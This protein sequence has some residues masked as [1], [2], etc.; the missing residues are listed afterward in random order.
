MAIQI[1]IN[2]TQ[3]A[4]LRTILELGPE[5]LGDVVDRIEGMEQAPVAPAELQA[6]IKEVVGEKPTAVDSILR[7]ALSLA[8]LRRRRKLDTDT[9]LAGILGG[10]KTVTPA[11]DGPSIAKWKELEPTF[12]RLISSG[13]VET[14]AKALDL[15]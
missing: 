1:N 9:V 13:K 6:A 11:W 10:L 2:K 7:Q 15:S 5:V 8:S 12:R 4:D 3:L 14:T